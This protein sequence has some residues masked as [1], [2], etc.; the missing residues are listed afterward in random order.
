MPK[1]IVKKGRSVLD[2]VPDGAG[3]GM[4]DIS[5]GPDSVLDVSSER[6]KA[7]IRCGAVELYKA[8]ASADSEPQ[9]LKGPPKSGKTK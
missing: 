8:P 1:V 6:A 3:A 4:R 7:L 5:Y 9:P 2:R